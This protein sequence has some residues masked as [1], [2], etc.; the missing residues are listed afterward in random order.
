MTE[1]E[2]MRLYLLLMEEIKCRFDVINSAYRNV[3]GFPPGMVREICY[4]QFR[5]L[6]EIIALGCLIAHGDISET[7]ALHDTYE[8]GKIIKKMERLNPDFYPQPVEVTGS[9]ITGRSDL[10]HLTKQELPKLWAR[11]GHILDRAPMAKFLETSKPSP[12]DFSDIM[13]WAEKIRI[14]LNSHWIT[15]SPGKAMVVGLVE[16]DTKRAF[17]HVYTFRG[18]GTAKLTII[19]VAGTPIPQ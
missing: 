5:L 2:K 14:L 18:D 1:E 16:K 12:V 11:S 9:T 17:A 6:C 15:L 19:R 3:D 13:E 10:P 8:P 4:L 7:R